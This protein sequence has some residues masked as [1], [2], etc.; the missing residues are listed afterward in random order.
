MKLLRNILLGF[1][2]LLVVL[3]IARNVILRV[4]IEQGIRVA[5]GLKLH[6]SKFDV[7]FLNPTISIKDLKLYN[8]K[9]CPD[10]VMVDVEE[11]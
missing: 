7:G 8:P 5:T 3:V 2:L 6:I 9:G 4:G 11:V 1:I 10:P